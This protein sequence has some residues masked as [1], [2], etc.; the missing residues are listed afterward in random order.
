LAGGEL[1]QRIADLEQQD[2][3]IGGRKKEEGRTC[4]EGRRGTTKAKAA[5]EK[6]AGCG[7]S[8]TSARL[9]G[10]ELAQKIA[11][12]KARK[13][14]RL[15]TGGERGEVM[16]VMNECK[17]GGDVRGSQVFWNFAQLAGGKLAQREAHLE[18]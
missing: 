14:S 7:S 5:E 11:D 8:G 1:A 17:H 18:P 12:L 13:T 9:A 2:R 6:S 15:A 10:G 16:K 4:Q 3:R